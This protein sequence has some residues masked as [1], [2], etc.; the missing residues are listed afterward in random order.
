MV[1][2]GV[3]AAVLAMMAAPLFAQE[4]TE[5]LKKEL[6]QLR[7]EVDGLKAVNSTRE[8]PSQ[9]KI[10]ADAMAADESP[11]MTLFKGSKLSGY[12]EAAFGFSFN[13]LN[14]NLGTRGGTGNNPVRF[15]DNS[16][17]AFYLHCVQLQ[18]GGLA[19]KDMIVGYHVELQ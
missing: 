8:I 19:T 5:Q 16:D 3:T 1:R 14:T 2:F 4:S 15:Y 11:V 9:G 18:L 17:N 12:V 13:Q 6:E 10:D 7:A